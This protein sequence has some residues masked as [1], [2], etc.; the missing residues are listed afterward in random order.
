ME[1]CSSYFCLSPKYNHVFEGRNSRLDGLQAAILLAKLPHLEGWIERRNEVARVYAQEL[2]GIEGLSLPGMAADGRY[3]FH[4]FVVRTERLDELA[5]FL[6][7][8]GIQ[9]GVHY[10]IALPKLQAY[11]YL[12]QATAPFFAN[13]ADTTLLSLPIGE[14][15][16]AADARRV[17]ASVREFF[18]AAKG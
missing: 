17:A 5:V 10:P 8:H 3:A 15:L 18:Q 7:E 6:K 12:N 4:L 14:H 9:T 2:A 11:T 13:R 1:Y 16:S